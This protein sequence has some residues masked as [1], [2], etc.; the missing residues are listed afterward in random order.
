[1][2]IV[3]HYIWCRHWY[4]WRRSEYLRYM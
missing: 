4:C 1:M 3:S 2:T